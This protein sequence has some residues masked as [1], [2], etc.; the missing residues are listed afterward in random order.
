MKI[1][2]TGTPGTGKTSVARELEKMGYDVIRIEEIADDFVIGYDAERNSKIIDEEAMDEYIKKIREEGILFIEGHLSHLLSVDGI[3]VLR[4]HPEELKRRLREKKWEERKVMENVEAEAIDIILQRALERHN[5]NKKIWEIDTTNRKAK[6][7]AK[8]II[9]IIN[10]ESNYG[11][12]D[13]SEWLM[14]EN[15]R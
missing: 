14:N 7:V 10:E 1:A 15:V 4:C 9:K 6:E 11:K 5:E 8:Q 2:L 12:I 13:W 3:V